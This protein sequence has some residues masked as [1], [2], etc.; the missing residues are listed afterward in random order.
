MGTDEPGTPGAIVGVLRILIHDEERTF[1]QR[2]LQQRVRQ[3]QP[4]RATSC[5]V[6]RHPEARGGQRLDAIIQAAVNEPKRKASKEESEDVSLQI[7]TLKAFGPEL[8]RISS[9]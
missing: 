7:P 9:R 8:Y 6:E 1:P 5:Q 4:C 3:V 2:A